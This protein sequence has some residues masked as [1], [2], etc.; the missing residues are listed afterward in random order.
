MAMYCPGKHKFKLI[1][2]EGRKPYHLC[3]CGKAEAIYTEYESAI[4]VP[5]KTTEIILAALAGATAAVG[6]YYVV[7]W[8][9]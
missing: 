8:F 1:R 4:H 9:M 5:L 6:F 2:P 3:H 7:K